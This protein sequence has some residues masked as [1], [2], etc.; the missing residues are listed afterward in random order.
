MSRNVRGE[1]TG[2][3]GINKSKPLP[4]AITFVD[5]DNDEDD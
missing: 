5:D 4:Q 2:G 3:S 1:V